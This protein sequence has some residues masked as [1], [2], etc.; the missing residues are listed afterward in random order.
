[1]IEDVSIAEN[2]LDVFAVLTNLNSYTIAWSHTSDPLPTFATSF[3]SAVWSVLST[4]TALHSLTL[5]MPFHDV[6][7]VFS[8]TPF[9]SP[10]YLTALSL[11]FGNDSPELE[12]SLADLPSFLNVL[13][14]CLRSLS[15][16][17]I[18]H[19]DLSIFFATLKHFSLLTDLS[20]S[21]PCDPGHLSD[22][23]GFAAFLNAHKTQLK[24]LVFS[25]HFC[26]GP[27]GAKNPKSTSQ[28]S[29]TWECHAFSTLSFPALHSLELRLNPFGTRDDYVLNTPPKFTAAVARE[30]LT[31]REIL[32]G[33]DIDK[34]PVPLT[35]SILGRLILLDD[36]KILLSPFSL[37]KEKSDEDPQHSITSIRVPESLILET[38]ILSPN[39]LYLLSS[40][41][42]RLKSL[43]LTY[44]WIGEL[45][46]DKEVCFYFSLSCW[47][48]CD[49]L[50]E[51]YQRNFVKYLRKRT[52][53]HWHL[54]NFTLNST[55]HEDAR[56]RCERAIRK[57]VPSL[58]GGPVKD[59]MT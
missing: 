17:V 30:K 1:M 48:T 32:K 5:D 2:L 49:S 29:S 52:Y 24:S 18:G 55:T 40:S 23:Q 59:H 16:Y 31:G 8:V 20:L 34:D 51:T 53:P 45:G 38:H 58:D 22:T 57:A 14:P 25:P 12:H 7:Q 19:F 41:L 44:T 10:T 36:L 4:T 6:C 46:C 28:E 39:L 11:K 37:P 56:R 15:L 43:N 26:C 47:Q 50:F 21:L 35:L 13:S 54:R 33:E 42:P 27:R 3:L 9:N